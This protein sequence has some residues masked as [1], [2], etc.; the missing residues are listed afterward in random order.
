M[1]PK[2]N[3]LCGF[4]TKTDPNWFTKA[5]QPWD[6]QFNYSLFTVPEMG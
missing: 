4:G 1:E 6:L 5:Q 3:T 2:T